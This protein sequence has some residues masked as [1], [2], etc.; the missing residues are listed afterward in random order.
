[1]TENINK[2]YE[3]KQILEDRTGDNFFFFFYL[4]TMYYHKLSV[5]TEPKCT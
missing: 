1:M 3:Y 2:I 5:K 4:W